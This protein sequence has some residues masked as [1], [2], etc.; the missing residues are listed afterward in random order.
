MAGSTSGW[1]DSFLEAVGLEDLVNT[2]YSKL[3]RATALICF[4]LFLVFV[5]ELILWK[6]FLLFCPALEFNNK[7]FRKVMTTIKFAFSLVSC[8]SDFSYFF[9]GVKV[10]SPG[11]PVGKGLT[12][13]AAAELGLWEG[14]PVGTSLIDAHAGGLGKSLLLMINVIV[15]LAM[16]LLPIWISIF[17]LKV[18]LELI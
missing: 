15:S 16:Y 3:G 2:K 9:W 4:F 17:L 12:K 1:I 18:S 7:I 10:G 11:E 8:E 5:F 6:L 13:N 14:M